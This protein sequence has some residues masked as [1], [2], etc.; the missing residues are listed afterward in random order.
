MFMDSSPDNHPPDDI[1]NDEE[2]ALKEIKDNVPLA[3]EVLEKD[4]KRMLGN[5][6]S[7]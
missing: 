2:E 3:K 5:V 1:N 6:N 7:D 4:F